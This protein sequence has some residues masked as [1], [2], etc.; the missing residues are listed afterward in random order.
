MLEIERLTDNWERLSN[1]PFDEEA[2]VGKLRELIPSNI[3]CYIAQSARGAKT[4]RELVA[5][6]MNQLTD[7]KTSM[8]QG[9]KQPQRNRL[10]R[11]VALTGSRSWV[12]LVQVLIVSPEQK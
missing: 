10:Q 1:K 5:L 4:Y 3:W 9:E 2:K 6:V 12:F 11:L 7:P 8:L